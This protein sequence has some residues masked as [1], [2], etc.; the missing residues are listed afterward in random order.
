M[1]IFVMYD[2]ENWYELSDSSLCPERNPF[3]VPEFDSRFT[4]YPALAVRID[5]VGKTIAERFARRYYTQSTIALPI[6][7]EDTRERLAQSGLPWG[8]AVAFDRSC[9]IGNFLPVETLLS[10]G[11]C[12][13]T[14]Q[15]QKIIYDPASH[16]GEIDRIISGISRTNM[17]KTGDIIIYGRDMRG[18]VLTPDTTLM[19]D[20]INDNS[21]NTLQ[22]KIR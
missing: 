1:K 18:I 8:R 20:S 7:A 15:E 5:R 19:V 21:K 4:A 11:T 6:V 22:F 9:L 10:Y 3:F 13:I 2:M 12:A 16:H 17:L 14:C